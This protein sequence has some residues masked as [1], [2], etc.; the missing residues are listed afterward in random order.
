M[1][2]PIYSYSSLGISF[3]CYGGFG[4]N[5]VTDMSRMPT[6]QKRVEAGAE[7]L[8]LKLPGWE[9]DIVPET[10]DLDDCQF[11][12]LGQLFG[13]FDN[14]CVELGID[15]ETQSG[16]LGFNLTE[17]ENDILDCYEVDTR[18]NSLTRLWRK[19]IKDRQKTAQSSPP[20]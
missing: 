9:R 8:D 19:L 14:G 5:G 1:R 15:R 2:G 7:Y 12:V 3:G 13:D 11:C 18:Y 4:S 6:L 16:E 20:E 10:L 17:R